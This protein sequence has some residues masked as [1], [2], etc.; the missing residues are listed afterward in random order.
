MPT[1]TDT[2][3]TQAD[4]QTGTLTNVEADAGDYLKIAET[5]ILSFDGSDDYISYPCTNISEGTEYTVEAWFKNDVGSPL[6]L[7]WGESNN[8]SRPYN[9]LYYGDTYFSSTPEIRWNIDSLTQLRLDAPSSGWHHVAIV[10]RAT[11]DRELFLDG[12]SVVS[13]ATSI[14][15]FSVTHGWIG[16]ETGYGQYSNCDKSDIRIWDIA[17]TQTEIQ[18]NMN[19][20]LTG[21]ESGLVVYFKLDEGD[22]YHV[23]DSARDENAAFAVPTWI[24]DEPLYFNGNRISPQLDLSVVGTVESSSVSWAETLN[25]ET[26]TIET[27]ISVDNGIHWGTWGTC[28]NGGSISGLSDGVSVLETL[29]ECRQSL[30]TDDRMVTPQLNSITVEITG[31]LGGET[32]TFFMFPF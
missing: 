31:E 14:S 17:R 25:G 22:G 18:D 10:Q 3:T 24:L 30:S 15:S 4:F 32:N 29:L 6:S 28:T 1:I 12:I 26:I 9:L 19:K 7:A 16:G 20:R 27:R 13:D 5:A 2:D 8:G 23:Y 11:N 21:D